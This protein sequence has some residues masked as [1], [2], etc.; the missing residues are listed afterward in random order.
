MTTA[1]SRLIQSAATARKAD[2]VLIDVGPSLGALNRAALIAADSVI[3][4]LGADLFSLRGLQSL[5]P[6]LRGWREAWSE[7]RKRPGPFPLPAGEMQPVGWVL[8]QH[9]AFKAQEPARAS[10]RWSARIPH[11]YSESVMGKAGDSSE[12]QELSALR[13]CRSLAPMAQEARKPMFRLT[14]ADGAIG[15]HAVAVA[16]CREDFENLAR[17]IAHRV[18]T[19]VAPAP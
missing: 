19:P 2:L 8:L 18:G 16:R 7:M 4:P 10:G 14:A 12:V 9:A 3:I 11:A 1:F 13:H 15:S 5:G 17:R 6:A